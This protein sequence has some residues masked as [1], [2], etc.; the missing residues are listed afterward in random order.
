MEVT[1]RCGMLQKYT[2][3]WFCFIIIIISLYPLTV[4]ADTSVKTVPKI[5][6]KAIRCNTGHVIRK[7]IAASKAGASVSH[8]SMSHLHSNSSTSQ[9]RYL[10]LI[11]PRLKIDSKYSD[12]MT[13]LCFSSNKQWMLTGSNNGIAQL[14]YLKTGQKRFSLYCGCGS[15]TSVAFVH[16]K[17]KLFAA[18]G[19]SSG[20]ICFWNVKNGRKQACFKA[21]EKEIIFIG[22]GSN[23][24]LI[25]AA[26]QN[27]VKIWN[28]NIPHL[29]KEIPVKSLLSVAVSRL[30]NYL[31]TG[32][33]DGKIACLDL[34]TCQE[35]S[36]LQTAGAS[37]LSLDIYRNRFL[38]AGSSN[39]H[40]QVWS[41]RTTRKI[42]E[43]A[44]HEEP[45]SAVSFNSKGTVIASASED[46]GIVLTAL[47]GRT[48]IG[49]LKGHTGKINDLEYSTNNKTLFSAGTDKV[50]R[51]WDVYLKKESCRL[52]S[53]RTGWA[54]IS[55]TGFFDGNLDGTVQDRLSAIHWQ[56][57]KKMFNMESFIEAYYRPGL[58]AH[59]MLGN[60]PLFKNRSDLEKQGVY[61]PP[62]V[63]ILEPAS[64]VHVSEKKVTIKFNV[65]N[66]GGGIDQIRIF[67]NG[68]IIIND[69]FGSDNQKITEGKIAEGGVLD[70]SVSLIHGKNEFRITGIS[71]DRI[72]SE[73][74][75]LIIYSTGKP[76]KN[77]PDLHT[78]T[79]G[80]NKY[81]N[82]SL[83][84]GFA[85]TDAQAVS[86]SFKK[87]YQKL[88]S[89]LNQYELYN[90]HAV[91]KSILSTLS[92]IADNS[93]QQD[94]VVLYFAGHGKTIDDT[95]YYIPYELTD[96]QNVSLL[97]KNAVSSWEL[98]NYI[99][100]IPAFKFFLLLDCCEA[101]AVVT[102]F[103]LTDTQRPFALLSR[104]TGMH[105]AAAAS[106]NSSAFEL[107]TLKHGLFTY[108]F[109]QGVKAKA[110]ISPRDSKISVLEIMKHLKKDMPVLSSQYKLPCQVPVLNSIGK[111][112]MISF[113]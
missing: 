26:A 75:K 99:S 17:K 59:I 110:D 24:D 39:G 15:V 62:A 47:A 42:L 81:K 1:I 5:I 4:H 85:V 41:L 50:V 43:R 71:H 113:K 55:G 76:E 83:D 31:I 70:C 89:N 22:S 45:V 106:K 95:W 16:I 7:S 66:Q 111:N 68:K 80:V 101:G 98:R 54:V 78:I 90:K 56:F 77:T 32:T 20:T 65:Q 103:D 93:E 109:L 60:R 108:S 100:Q 48:K 61:Q 28:L 30:G 18:T 8:K 51:I 58:L 79:V 84:L 63:T 25:T 21:H 88:F 105:I 72:E 107:T 49:V 82:P 112:F 36:V 52:V 9:N 13:S 69:I 102:A 94:T 3:K 33:M 96:I 67:H 27:S 19:H 23:H 87:S 29:K 40:L 38:A 34:K 104:S 14:W 74:A 10:R 53:M 73:P 2:E 86:A 46:G 37:V 35:I 6:N 57:K 11:R 91:K 44:W 92:L 97:K 12:A 64:G